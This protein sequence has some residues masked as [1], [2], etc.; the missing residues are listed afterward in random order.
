MRWKSHRSIEWT[1]FRNQ[2]SITSSETASL[3]MPIL[4]SFL[5]F[6][7]ARSVWNRQTLHRKKIRIHLNQLRISGKILASYVDRKCV[8]W[9]NKLTSHRV[10]QCIQVLSNCCTNKSFYHC[11]QTGF[12]KV[13]FDSFNSIVIFSDAVYFP[14]S[15]I[16]YK[17][18]TSPPTVNNVCN[19]NKFT[20][21]RNS[22]QSMLSQLQFR[23]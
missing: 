18:F 3:F 9:V 15:I 21:Q 12:T 11:R 7:N 4:F 2:R 19:R 22:E 10:P 6:L 17:T 23:R 5:C 13:Y 8:R 16:K 1:K 14:I 20:S